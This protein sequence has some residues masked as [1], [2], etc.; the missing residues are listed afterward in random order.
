[1][2]RFYKGLKDD[3]KDNLYK[4][5]ISDILVKYIQRAIRIDDCLYIYCIEKRS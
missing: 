2:I 1:M 5:D 4:K 3:V